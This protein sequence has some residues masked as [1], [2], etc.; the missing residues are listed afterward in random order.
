M[1]K[2]S[3]H[4]FLSSGLDLLVVCLPLTSETHGMLSASEYAILAATSA[5]AKRERRCFLVNVSRG[6]ILD[7]AALCAALHRGQLSGAALD[8]ASPEP[9]PENDPLWKAPNCFISPHISWSGTRYLD[10]CLDILMLNLERQGKG[11][12]MINLVR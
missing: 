11:L 10:R 9:L 3:F 6:G 4:K 7:Q 2:P 8:V 1:D 5:E 12:K